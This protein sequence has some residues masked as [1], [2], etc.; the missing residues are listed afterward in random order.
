MMNRFILIAGLFTT[1]ALSQINPSARA[2][3]VLFSDTFESRTNGSGD[4]NG[5]PAGTGNGSSS[6]GQNNNALGGTLTPTY[7]TTTSRTGGANQVVGLNQFDGALGNHGH[8]SNGAVAFDLG[9]LLSSSPLGFTVGFD[10]DRRTDPNSLTTSGGYVA[11]GLGLNSLLPVDL[12]GPAAIA[13]TE[14][15]VLFQQGA[16]GNAANGSAFDNFG[17]LNLGNFDYLTPNDVHNALLTFTP[18][19][20]GSYGAN[21]VIGYDIRVDGA[22]L[23]AGTF[24]VASEDLNRFVFSNNQAVQNYVDNIVVS[25]IVGVPEPATIGL[26]SVLGMVGGAWRSR[27][28]RASSL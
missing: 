4:G 25:Q 27:R 20:A 13:R 6:W 24:T 8:L 7:I 1:S 2:A 12:G 11:F 10:F 28:R 14:F 22:S 26:L 9:T 21:S 3:I 17:A 23:G 15:G 16:N 5:N 19:V 18:T